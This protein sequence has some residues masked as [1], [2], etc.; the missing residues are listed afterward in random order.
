MGEEL[1]LG[2][3]PGALPLGQ[4]RFRF[5]GINAQAA[6]AQ[7]NTEHAR[8]DFVSAPFRTYL[9]GVDRYIAGKQ[10]TEETLDTIKTFRAQLEK[11]R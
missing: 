5:R 9:G 11:G 1:D 6:A 10:M 7:R 2:K 3:W 4:E 8:G